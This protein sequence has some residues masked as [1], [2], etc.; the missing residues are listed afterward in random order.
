[1][2]ELDCRVVLAC[3]GI[4]HVNRG[5]EASVSELFEATKCRIDVQLYQGKGRS[6]GKRCVTTIGRRSA[7]YRIWPFQYVSSYSRYRNENLSFAIHFVISIF[8]RPADII[9]TPDHCLAVLLKRI[10]WFLPRR[11]TVVFSNGAP[12]E[13]K[14]CERF[15]AVHQKSFEH[16]SESKGTELEHRSWL[17]ANGFD[18]DRLRQPDAFCRDAVLDSLEVDKQSVVVLALAAHNKAHKRIDWLLTEFAKLDQKRFSLVIAGQPTEDKEE[19]AQLSTDLGCDA[20][21]VTVP[22]QDVPSLI[23]ASDLMVLSSLSEGFPRSVAESMGGARHIFVHPHDNAKWIIDDNTYC[24]VDMTKDSALADAVQAAA[25]N[26]ERVAASAAKNHQRF[27]DNFTWEKVA[28]SYIKMF[29]ELL[30]RK[31]SVGSR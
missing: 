2:S 30:N 26:P 3:S 13:N 24:F 19:L 31:Q 7:I 12:F 6:P 21:F 8:L 4:G 10:R 1:V 5:Y 25:D 22:Q 14:F 18:R 17:I 23:W 15:E 20:K 9:F 27:L 28:D 29:A 11:P 16:Y